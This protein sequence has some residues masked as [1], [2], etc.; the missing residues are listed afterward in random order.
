MGYD[1]KPQRGGGAPAW[2]VEA[3]R[4]QTGSGLLPIFVRV[5]RNGQ[6]CFAIG[7]LTYQRSDETSSCCVRDRAADG[8]CLPSGLRRRRT[9]SSSLL[10]TSEN[11]VSRFSVPFFAQRFAKQ[12]N[13]QS[14]LRGRSW[15]SIVPE[16]NASP[17]PTLIP[18]RCGRASNRRDTSGRFA[19]EGTRAV[20]L[21]GRR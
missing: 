8:P 9:R 10:M 18:G 12:Q 14:R 11:L 13:S 3:S 5:S 16:K 2:C 20:V 19:C 1:R 7:G 17:R 21:P 15:P 4:C 6:N